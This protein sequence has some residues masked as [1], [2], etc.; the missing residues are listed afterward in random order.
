MCYIIKVNLNY[1]T[2]NTHCIVSLLLIH[3]EVWPLHLQHMQNKLLI[4]YN[5]HEAYCSPSGNSFKEQCLYGQSITHK[6][7]LASASTAELKSWKTSMNLNEASLWYFVHPPEMTLPLTCT[8]AAVRT[9]DCVWFRNTDSRPGI[10]TSFLL[11]YKSCPTQGHRKHQ[12]SIIVRL[13]TYKH[14]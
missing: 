3:Y 9:Y 2:I 4:T 10:D 14:G 5:I 12:N 13:K 11:H 7:L 6:I 8:S 1:T